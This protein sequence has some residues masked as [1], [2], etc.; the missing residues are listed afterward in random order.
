MTSASTPEELVEAYRLLKAGQRQQAGAILKPYL[1]GHQGDARAWWLMAHAVSNQDVARQCLEQ[2]LKI[3]PTH[4]RARARLAALAPPFAAKPAEIPDDEPDD[5]FFV[6][7]VASV[8]P[9][10][11]RLA[12][13]VTAIR[14]LSEASPSPEGGAVPSFEEFAAQISPGIDPFTGE[15]VDNPFAG[16]DEEGTRAL[17]PAEQPPVETGGAHVFD[18]A[19]YGRIGEHGPGEAQPPGTGHQPDWGPG[20]AF[21]VEGQPAAEAP[22]ISVAE[23]RAATR[24]MVFGL[25][26]FLVFLLVMALLVVADD[27]GWLHLSGESGIAT[28]VLSGGLFTMDYPA[29]W[30]ARCEREAL[31]YPVCGVANHELY[32]EVDFFAG[33]E[34]DLST[35]IAQGMRQSL[36]GEGLPD[37]RMSVIVM[38]VPP[39]SLAYDNG[40]WAKTKHEW[41]QRGL[42]D[43]PDAEVTYERRTIQVDG[44]AAYYYAFTSA[45]TWHEAAWDVYVE[46]GGI[47][48]WLRV[49][50]AGPR[51]SPIPQNVVDLMIESI[52]FTPEGA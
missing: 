12:K 17:V 5:S 14:R 7:P 23:K 44:N 50:Y 34:I 45:G 3:D 28:S 30:N 1:A 15:P 26:G 40:S 35:L 10:S 32:N 16:L 31:G 9:D 38:D 36:T 2:V 33:R 6:L 39:T 52:R 41:H 20:L 29:G 13:P 11:A 37:E 49:D 27:Q 18:P 51:E 47:V 46:H 4:E 48:L 19:A 22:T 25:G 24:I 8:S 43:D 42:S 21:V